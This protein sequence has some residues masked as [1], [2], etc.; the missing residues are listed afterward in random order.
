MLSFYR[1]N[2]VKLRVQIEQNMKAN[3]KVTAVRNKS[4]V[5]NY[6]F[7]LLFAALAFIPVAALAQNLAPTPRPAEQAELSKVEELVLSQGAA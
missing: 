4:P 6:Y 5:E 7:K 3:G 2:A 1:C